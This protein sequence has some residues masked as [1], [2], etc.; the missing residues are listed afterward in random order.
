MPALHIAALAVHPACTPLPKGSA[1]HF[2]NILLLCLALFSSSHAAAQDTVER[3]QSGGTLNIGYVEKNPP[4]SQ[5]DA[6]RTQPAGYAIDICNRVA[7]SL[8]SELKLPHM[9]VKYV[10]VTFITRFSAL[11]KGEIDIECGASTITRERLEKYSFSP[12][13]FVTGVRLLA[14]KSAAVKIIDDLSHKTI[15]V[16]KDT[17]GEKLIKEQNERALKARVLRVETLDEGFDA[18]ARDKADAFA[19]DDILLYTMISGS[20][21]GADFEVTGRFMS[22]EPYGAMM[23]KDDSRFEKLVSHGM[24]QLLTSQEM[25]RIYNTWFNTRKLKLPMSRL[26]HEAFMQ[27][28]SHP[29]F[30]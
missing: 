5:I 14:K 13:Y 11:E 25:P 9:A 4:F 30:P 18:V 21:Q 23:R 2:P 22:I 1:R 26:T 20:P 17:T 28:N 27:P 6:G 24:I 15:A 7:D 8:R 10:P 3:L 12:A 16:S 29:A 19:M